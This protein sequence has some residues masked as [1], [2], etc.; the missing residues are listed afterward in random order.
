MPKGRF[1]TRSASGLVQTALCNANPEGGH[2]FKMATDMVTHEPA[3][4]TLPG[5]LRL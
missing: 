3:V 4:I 5:G 1:S 2:A